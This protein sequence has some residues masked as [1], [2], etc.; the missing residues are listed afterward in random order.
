MIKRKWTEKED[1]FILNNYKN[2]DIELISKKIDR[3]IISI[4]ARMRFLGIRR[5]KPKT[6]N[7]WTDEQIQILKDNYK[8]LSR[9]KLSL[10]IGQSNNNIRTKLIELKLVDSN[11]RKSYKVNESKR[12]YDWSD[13]KIKYLIDNFDK[14]PMKLMMEELNCSGHTIARKAKSIGLKSRKNKQ[15]RNIKLNKS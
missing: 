15:C 4:D 14:T 1:L 3:T 5:A 8:V 11:N 13:D 6:P 9:E 2:M 7:I 12:F 10:L